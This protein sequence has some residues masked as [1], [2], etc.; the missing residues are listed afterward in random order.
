MPV[1]S[2]GGT[3]RRSPSPPLSWTVALA[4]ALLDGRRLSYKD[5]YE[6]GVVEW[7]TRMTDVRQRFRERGDVRLA[8]RWV[9][10]NGTRFKE[11]WAEAIQDD[12]QPMK[13]FQ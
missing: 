6:F 5:S 10:D 4:T 7:H 13:L 12:E 11:Y 2:P 9:E 1:R 8:S 3:P